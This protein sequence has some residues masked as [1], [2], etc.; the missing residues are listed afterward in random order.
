MNAKVVCLLLPGI[1]GLELAAYGLAEEQVGP[2]RDHPIVSQ[3]DWPKGIVSL[4]RH[5][6][7]VYSIWVNGNENFYF[8]A[9]L[10]QVNELLALF[11]KARLR[12]H[13]V[14]IK[15]GKPQAQTFQKAT[16]SYNVNLQ[17]L[18]GIALARDDGGDGSEPRLTVYV[19]ETVPAGQLVLPGNLILHSD[20]QEIAAK[21]EAAKPIRQLWHGRVQFE[22]AG[23]AAGPQPGIQ[24]RIS[25]W[26]TGLADEVKLARIGG[27]GW[28]S[29]RLSEAEMAGLK[30]GQSWLTI[31]VGNWLTEAQKTDPRFPAE[32]L[33]DK[34]T[35]EAVKVPAPKFYYG[36]IL[37]EDG[38]APKLEPQPWPGA[39]IMVDFSYAGSAEPDGEGYFKLFF[40]KDQFEQ[41]KSDKP[42]K[43]IY[44]PDAQQGHSTARLVFPAD[45]LSQDK[46]RAGTV[47][48]PRPK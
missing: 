8:K 12:D 40:T 47:M 42:R 7:R 11:A 44:M 10:A 13:E 16:I 45:L 27:D 30:S 14:W 28:F 17:V 5:E 41:I 43:N 21:S 29:A 46:T 24:T 39:R 31:T 22:D 33:G 18:S 6:S 1:F 48:I 20:I 38:T 4:P 34:S 19:D 25:L 32:K 36:R 9:D 2:D 26:E 35:V 3:P 15:N 23:A 37:F